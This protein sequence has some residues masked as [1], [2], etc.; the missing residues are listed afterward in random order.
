MKRNSADTDWEQIG[1]KTVQWCSDNNATADVVEYVT[2]G[3]SWNFGS[4]YFDDWF[5]E[6]ASTIRIK[7]EVA[8]YS[9]FPVSARLNTLTVDGVEQAGFDNIYH[10]NT[11]AEGECNCNYVLVA[12]HNDYIKAGTKNA[13]TGVVTPFEDQM[14]IEIT[15]KNHQEKLDLQNF[16]FGIE[17]AQ[18]QTPSVEDGY[19]YSYNEDLEANMLTAIPEYST[20]SKHIT[21]PN[22]LI[23]EDGSVVDIGYVFGDGDRLPGLNTYDEE[24][25]LVDG[26]YS[27]T[28]TSG[29]DF[30]EQY[31][32]YNSFIYGVL[33]SDS[34]TVLDYTFDN[35]L[36]LLSI[37]I[38]ASVEIIGGQKD[39]LRNEHGLLA[40]AYSLFVEE[41]NEYYYSKNNCIIS[42]LEPT[43]LVAGC[44]TSVIPNFI[45][46]IC[47]HAF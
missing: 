34:V 8:N 21:L 25:E 35:C 43:K 40:N 12:L 27:V 38:P 6:V 4:I 47:N 32:L 39:A 26:Y 44:N 30:V 33:L 14:V 3:A 9:T 41:G 13:Q 16:D 22:Q 2:D 11:H 29:L 46:T 17:F 24:G 1:N 18:T 45:T 19:E 10:H 37:T 28:L 15:L 7:I 31:E 42:K 20:G 36:N 23:D 5:N